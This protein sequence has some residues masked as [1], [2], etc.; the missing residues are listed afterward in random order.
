METTKEGWFGSIKGENKRMVYYVS[1]IDTSQ[2]LG[3][4]A[5]ANFHHLDIES[6]GT[7]KR[8][9]YQSQKEFRK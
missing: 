4:R 1:M 2:R 7:K 6:E 9:I 3:F 8:K 5:I